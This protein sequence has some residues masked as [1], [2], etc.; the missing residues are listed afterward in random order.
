MDKYK[1]PWDG[2]IFPEGTYEL[3][4][5]EQTKPKYLFI[6][7]MKSIMREIKKAFGL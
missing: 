1:D 7:L 6:E 3:I 5:D 4:T 2:V